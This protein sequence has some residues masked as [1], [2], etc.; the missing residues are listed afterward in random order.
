MTG[1]TGT[2]LLIDDDEN[3]HSMLRFH[4][5]RAGF[6]LLSATNSEDAL[7][8]INQ[9]PDLLA[10]LVDIHLPRPDMGWA[11]LGKLTKLRQD[12]LAQTPI[13]VYSVDDD[14]N[15]AK[16]A[17][18][19]EHIVKPINYKEIITLIEKYAGQRSKA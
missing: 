9:Q 17:G 8:T 10:V 1:P 15:R 16:L 4:L 2:V 6:A 12:V 14:K 7:R 19:D 11:L 13:V 3:V 5:E 18:A